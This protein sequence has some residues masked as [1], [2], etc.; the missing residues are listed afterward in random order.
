MLFKWGSLL[1]FR[2]SVFICYFF[3]W[4]SGVVDADAFALLSLSLLQTVLNASI[5]ITQIK[6]IQHGIG[7][8][9][10]L[11]SILNLNRVSEWT[12]S[13]WQEQQQQQ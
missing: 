13:H 9:F 4:I 8:G 5:Q 7:A 1:F 6:L 11:N 10:F 3:F 2:S 12:V